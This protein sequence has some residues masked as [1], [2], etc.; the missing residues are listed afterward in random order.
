MEAWP[1]SFQVGAAPYLSL[2]LVLNYFHALDG[3]SR[4]SFANLIVF[5]L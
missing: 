1:M 5:G 2:K 4:I 3:S